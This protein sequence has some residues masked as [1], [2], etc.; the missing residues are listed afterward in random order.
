MVFGE[1]PN[2]RIGWGECVLGLSHSFSLSLWVHWKKNGLENGCGFLEAELCQT[3]YTQGFWGL[4]TR[5]W[6]EVRSSV[7]EVGKGIRQQLKNHL[8]YCWKVLALECAESRMGRLSRWRIR[9]KRYL[10]QIPPGMGQV[11][12]E[13]E[14][15]ACRF[16]ELAEVPKVSANQGVM[17]RLSE[18]DWV[19]GDMAWLCGLYIHNGLVGSHKQL[20]IG[21]S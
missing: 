11:F 17:N 21:K 14:V 9:S 16:L 18:E 19:S 2:F 12:R 15:D 4:N 3:R 20:A 13:Q 10:G 1:S 7:A 8:T 5:W 6:A